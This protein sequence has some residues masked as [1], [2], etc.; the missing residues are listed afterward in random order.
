ME[1]YDRDKSQI[2]IVKELSLLIRYYSRCIQNEQAVP[3][4]SPE[5]SAHFINSY[6][7]KVKKLRILREDFENITSGIKL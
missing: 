7:E 5:E 4:L 6:I 1:T 3:E 2:K